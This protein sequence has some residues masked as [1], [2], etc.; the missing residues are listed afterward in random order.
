MTRKS[1]REI[2]RALEDLADDS[3]QPADTTHV[4]APFVAY[5]G[6]FDE[7]DLPEGLTASTTSTEGATFHVVEPADESDGDAP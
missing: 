7:A 3:E 6:S 4:T 5:D 2:E 1:E